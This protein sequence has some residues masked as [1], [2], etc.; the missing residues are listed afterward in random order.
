MYHSATTAHCSHKLSNP[1]LH[2]ITYKSNKDAEELNDVSVS[3][4]VQAAKE[5]VDNGDAGTENHARPVVHVDDDAER[6]A[7]GTS[8]IIFKPEIF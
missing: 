1:W 5:S 7:C 6:G 2:K 8:G 3:D 4:A